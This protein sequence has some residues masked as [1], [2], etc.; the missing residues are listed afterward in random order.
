MG[1]SLDGLNNER[2]ILPQLQIKIPLLSLFS[3]LFTYDVIV[4]RKNKQFTFIARGVLR[5]P[6]CSTG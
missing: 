6:A 1:E 5:F 3:N 4:N 2:G